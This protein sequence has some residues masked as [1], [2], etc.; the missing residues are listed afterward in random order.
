MV[1]P[2]APHL[3]VVAVVATAA[4][5]AAVVFYLVTRA[6]HKRLPNYILPHTTHI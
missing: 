4:A 1:Q 2:A 3:I 6:R 5:A